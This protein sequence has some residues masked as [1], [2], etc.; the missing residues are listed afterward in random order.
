MF[1]VGDL[2]RTIEGYSHKVWHGVIINV[3]ASE[4]YF[5]LLL[6]EPTSLGEKTHWFRD[7]YLEMVNE[8]R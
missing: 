8:R 2:V 4:E 1:K 3:E 6:T 5:Q 7:T